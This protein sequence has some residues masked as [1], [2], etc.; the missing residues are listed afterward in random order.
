MN[1][2]NRLGVI[3]ATVLASGCVGVPIGRPGGGVQ[4][5]VPYQVGSF[6]R[7]VNNCAPFLDLETV[8]G[9]VVEKLPYGGSTTVPLISMP[10]GGSY[11]RMFLTAKGYTAVREYL[12]SATAEFGVSTYEGSRSEVWEVN[13]L[14]LPSGR[15]GCQ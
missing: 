10:F 6:V 12:G 5:Y 4:L 14:H 13:R 15:G 3:L 11:R 9:V 2:L 7:V 8:N 1:R